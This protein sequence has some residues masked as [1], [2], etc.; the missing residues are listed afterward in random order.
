MNVQKPCSF[1]GLML[2]ISEDEKRPPVCARCTDE[3]NGIK[4]DDDKSKFDPPDDDLNDWL[5]GGG[6]GF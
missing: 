2:V 3:L 1:C 4:F 6:F 5:Q